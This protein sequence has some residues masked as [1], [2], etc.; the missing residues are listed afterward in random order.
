MRTLSGTLRDRGLSRAMT[1]S[2][3]Q[4]KKELEMIV[5]LKM[6]QGNPVSPDLKV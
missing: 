6:K 5:R 2:G 4:K 1:A 3:W